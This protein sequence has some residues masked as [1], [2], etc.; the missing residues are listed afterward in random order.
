MSNMYPALSAKM[1]DWNYYI[2]RMC[3]RDVA[4]EVGITQ[5]HAGKTLDNAIQRVLNTDR[6]KNQ[7]IDFLR[8]DDRFF[9]SI[10][11]A[12]LDGQPTFH[13]VRLSDGESPIFKA[14]GVDG[15]FGILTFDGGQKYYAL[16]GQHRLAA[17]REL[18]KKGDEKLDDDQ[19][20]VIMILHDTEDGDFKIKY[21]RLFAWLNRYAKKISKDE[22]IILDEDDAFAILTR[23][24]I[25]DHA[26]FSATGE[27][28]DLVLTK[29]KNIRVGSDYFTSLQTLYAVNTTLLRSAARQDDETWRNNKAFIAKRPGEEDLDA[30][31]DEL[32]VYWH[33]LL[34][35]L[36]DLRKLPKK[37]RSDSDEHADHMFFRPIGQEIVMAKLARRLL[38]DAGE[39]GKVTAAKVAKAIEP[40]AGID[41]N[42]RSYPWRGIVATPSPSDKHQHVMRNEDRSKAMAYA[43]GLAKRMVGIRDGE[44]GNDGGLYDKWKHFVNLDPMPDEKGA[45]KI[46]EQ[47]I[48]PLL[49]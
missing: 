25:S 18:V 21:R 12:A 43:L 42:L 36:P 32:A 38:D 24:L 48:A 37:M 13:P 14:T 1:G 8:R 23:R 10:V 44:L 27:E 20:S 7:I 26:F 2:V 16:D 22:E 29:G 15:S 19:I 47:K 49:K 3:L 45:K 4:K 11:V 41:W 6:V 34:K 46:W 30:L 40:M 5:Y 9:S 35:A 31:Y 17:I 39:S 33:G 28:S